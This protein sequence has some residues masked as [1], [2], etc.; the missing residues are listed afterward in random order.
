[1]YYQ[2][3]NVNAIFH[4]GRQFVAVS[5]FSVHGLGSDLGSGRGLQLQLGWVRDT[6]GKKAYFLSYSL[7]TGGQKMTLSIS[8]IRLI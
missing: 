8:K 6:D 7:S 1:M 5:L 4:P 2:F 3:L